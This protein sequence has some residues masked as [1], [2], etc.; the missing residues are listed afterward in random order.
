[1]LAT[2]GASSKSPT[3]CDPR[4][5]ALPVTATTF[6]RIVE[7]LMVRLSG[8]SLFDKYSVVCE[9][10]SGGGGWTS[11]S[12]SFDIGCGIPPEAA[13]LKGLSEMSGN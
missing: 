13:R 11:A 6:G 10:A 9:V 2:R 8:A 7:R 4:N 3:K 5:P 1:M 12:V